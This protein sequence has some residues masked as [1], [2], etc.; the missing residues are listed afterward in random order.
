MI[1][2]LNQSFKSLKRD[3][4]SGELRL[5]AAAVIVAVASLTSVHFFTDRVRQSTE[6]NATELLAAD[7][8]LGSPE[9]I[10]TDIINQAHDA[11]LITTITTSFRSVI[12]AGSKMHIS[13]V[14]AV[15][16]G[17]P[18]RGKLRTSDKLFGEERD[19]KELPAAGTVWADSR[20]LQMLGLKVGDTLN[21]GASTMTVTRVLTYE[22]DRGGDLFNIAPRLLMNSSDLPATKLILPGSRV[23]YRLL[24]GGAADAV[25]LFRGKVESSHSR[26]LRIRSIRDARPEIKTALN[27]AEQFLG[28][29]ALVS[30]ALAGLAVAMSAQRYATR[31]FDNCA[32]MRCLGTEQATITNLYLIQLLI[33][34]VISSLIGC[35]IGYFAQQGL[36]AMASG[37]MKHALPAPSLQPVATGIITGIITV[38]GFAMPQILRLRNVSPLRVL[39]RDLEPLPI[40]N[41]TAYAFAVCALALLTPWES[42][43]ARLT[44]YVFL[45]MIATALVLVIGTSF[46]IS[47][48][49]RLRSRVGVASRYGLANV[50]RRKNQS[51][52]QIVGI[53]LGV[54]VMLLL[55]LVR[56][57]LLESWRDSIP[58]GTP[59]YF[60]INIQPDE[61]DTVRSY[62]KR[63]AV[64]T[65]Y[66][67]VMIQARLATINGKPVN[68][69]GFDNDRSRR[70]AD[71][72]YNL[73]WASK[74]PK[75]NRLVSGKWWGE[76]SNGQAEFSLEQ[77][78]A[79]E[80][81]VALG[82]M[83]TFTV[84]GREVTGKITSIRFIDWD[85]FD[86]NFFVVANPGSLDG[87]PGTWVTSL[88]LPPEQRPLMI[89]LVRTFPSVTVIDVD[90]ILD[91]VRGIMN[92][93]I[94]TVEFVFGFTL[95]AG[96]VVLLA[97]LQTTHDERIYESALLSSLGANRRQILS[98]LVAEFLCL[99]LAAGILA[100]FAASIIEVVLTEAVFRMDVVINPWVWIIAPLTCVTLIVLAGLAGTRKV[101]N[102]P[103]IVVL[104]NA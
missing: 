66:M 9:P 35:G 48:L 56:T 32:I 93:V 10:T 81:G 68:P 92:Q 11:G 14:K 90:A 80:L 64:E 85:S 19:A 8:V 51:I 44:L 40:K 23:R 18:I 47:W 54:M 75:S 87:F 34:S 77:D 82:D 22:P 43:N 58:E 96:L 25:N 84:T 102:T 31:H 86:V 67:N 59:N 16:D 83:L 46:M 61:V 26:Q 55:T 38:L 88:Y 50:A 98:S 95:L 60:L 29:A 53:G 45:G 7:L 69:E 20:L 101:L 89:D 63:H 79:R 65:S 103:P 73:T 36:S 76:R 91:Q 39:R 12:V 94:R 97:A 62:L 49:N 13:E 27:R 21:L 3:W 52:S 100:A 33:L 5:I 28:L 2:I 72:N 4:R 30:I 6:L 42:G 17:Y 71:R 57:D 74:L 104:R 99:G 15:E 37:F 24:V 1:N 78:I 41:M 70:M